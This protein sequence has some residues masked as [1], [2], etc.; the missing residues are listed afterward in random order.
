MINMGHIDT[1]DDFA[2]GEKTEAED[3]MTML[4]FEDLPQLL[5]KTTNT[6]AVGNTLAWWE[7]ISIALN[8]IMAFKGLLLYSLIII[9]GKWKFLP[10]LQW[11]LANI[12]LMFIA[13]S[14]A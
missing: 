5:L 2:T 6:L 11:V 14:V 8:L 13:I 12:F 10:L 9:D 7:C 4:L 3:L 1:N